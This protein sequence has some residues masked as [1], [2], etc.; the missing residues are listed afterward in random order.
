MGCAQWESYRVNVRSR[1]ARGENVDRLVSVHFP[2][3]ILAS[4]ADV[5]TP[6][7]CTSRTPFTS[8]RV[9]KPCCPLPSAPGGSQHAHT[10]SWRA[11]LVC[12]E[13]HVQRVFDASNTRFYPRLHSQRVELVRNCAPQRPRSCLSR[14]RR[15]K[16]GNEKPYW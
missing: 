1:L 9:A 12:H 15:Y 2:S 16:L 10:C 14:P 11:R 8:T 13:N 3:S 4:G 7:A 6:I 5:D